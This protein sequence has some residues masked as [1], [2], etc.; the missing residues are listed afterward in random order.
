MSAVMN[1]YMDDSGSRNP[2]HKLK[3]VPHGRDWFSLGGV[4]IKEVDEPLA[5][6]QIADFC[7]SWNIAVPLH[8]VDIRHKAR[9]FSWLAKLEKEEL[10]RF[11]SELE[12]LL[13]GLPVIGIACV[14][15]RPGYNH[16][17]LE[18]YGKQRW[19]LCKTAFAVAVERAAKYAKR[20]GYRLRVLP[21]RCSRADDAKLKKYYDSLREDG[22]P[23]SKNSSSKYQ[24]LSPNDFK[25]TLYDFKTKYK[26]S[27]LTQVADL[28]L[29]PMCMGGY[30]PENRP[31]Q[32][33][34][35]SRKL[36]DSYYDAEDIEACGIKYSCFELARRTVA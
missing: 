28:Y 1:F 10:D 2:D 34:K 17:Y 3:Q 29:W 24:P 4:L 33:L 9:S 21:E 14:I 12:T 22:Q 32:T 20:E 31:Y 6:K 26:S 13:V 19:M 30:H 8:S 15:D 27:L 25:V 18:K 23:F 5:R 35:L 16:R 11:Y 36:I 7:N